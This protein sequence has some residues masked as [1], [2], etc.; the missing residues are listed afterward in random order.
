LSWY[1]LFPIISYIVQRGKCRHCQ[2][3]ISLIYPFVEVMTGFLF[4]FCYITFGF[5]IELMTALFLVSMLM[6]LFVSDIAYMLIPYIFL[7]LTPWYDLIL[8]VLSGFLLIAVI[9]I[10]SNGGMG[11]GDMKLF[12][13]LGIVLGWKNTLIAF[14]IAIFLGSLI[15]SYLM[16]VNKVKRKEPI[17]F[18]PYI[19]FGAL[20]SYFYGE[21]MI[22]LYMSLF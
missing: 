1:E 8:G 11:A 18:G 12:C 21:Y 10:V 13:V 2:T 14:F 4:M 5:E 17:P 9:I 16:L 22:T 15:G 7:L 6:I 20:V 3:H 19:V